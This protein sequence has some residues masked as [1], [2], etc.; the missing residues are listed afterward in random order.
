M[1]PQLV[2]DYI[3]LARSQG[4]QQRQWD[5]VFHFATAAQLCTT[6]HVHG[7]TVYLGLNYWRKGTMHPT[8][9]TLQTV[10]DLYL[11]LAY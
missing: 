1:F 10:R 4:A 3:P 11:Y 6:V 8:H 7:T 5:G 2:R 9:Y